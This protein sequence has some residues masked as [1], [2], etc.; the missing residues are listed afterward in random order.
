MIGVFENS[1]EKEAKLNL[2]IAKLDPDNFYCF[3]E[4]VF[5]KKFPR[6]KISKSLS[7]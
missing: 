3:L 2:L 6:M 5:I 1:F 4:K 7:W